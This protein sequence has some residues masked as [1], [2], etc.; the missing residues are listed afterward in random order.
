M[1]MIIGNRDDKPIKTPDQVAVFISTFYTAT[2]NNQ[3]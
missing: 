1:M 2:L 3:L